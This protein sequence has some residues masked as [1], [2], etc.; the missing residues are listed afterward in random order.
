MGLRVLLLVLSL[1]IRLYAQPLSDPTR[2]QF[3]PAVYDPASVGP[4]SYRLLIYNAADHSLVKTIDLGNPTPD[5]DGKIRATF[6]AL[7]PNVT[8][9]ARVVALGDGGVLSPPSAPT[10]TF[11][12]TATVQ[13]ESPDRTQVP[14]ALQVVDAAGGIWALGT[15]VDP[16]AITL[17]GVQASN[18][19]GSKILYVKPNI[20]VFGTDSRWYVYLTTGW[21]PQD[22]PPAPTPQPPQ[23]AF[24][25]IANPLRFVAR[26]QFPTA[27]TGS[28]L[29]WQTNRAAVVTFDPTGAKWTV[30]AKDVNGCTVVATR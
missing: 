26:V 21:T 15:P 28:Q 10:N 17:N 27:A 2:V 20:Y 23:P 1:P 6:A 5:A 3:D 8:Y 13:T 16:S 30:T 7:P 25:C 11:V 22:P 24:D 18:G 9:E 14:P 19:R 4:P 12:F 29:R